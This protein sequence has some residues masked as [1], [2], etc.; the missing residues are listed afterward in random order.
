MNCRYSCQSVEARPELKFIMVVSRIYI[1]H[2][3]L[4][5]RT[6]HLSQWTS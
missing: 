2:A 1:V 5:N 3:I 4:R 6:A